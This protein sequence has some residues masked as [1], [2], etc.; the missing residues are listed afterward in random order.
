M[1]MLKKQSRYDLMTYQFDEVDCR[2]YPDCLSVNLNNFKYNK[3]PKEALVRQ[4]DVFR[5]DL[6]FHNKMSMNNL[7]D[8]VLWLND[9][10]SRRFMTAGAVIKIPRTADIS[11]YFIK[12]RQ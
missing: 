10:P 8:I 1:S 2:N 11:S 12:N 6:F 5:P 4:N 3:Q 7:E 9:I